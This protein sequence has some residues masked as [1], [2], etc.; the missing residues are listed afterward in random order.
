[1][2]EK[3]TQGGGSRC[4]RKRGAGSW[5]QGSVAIVLAILLADAVSGMPYVEEWAIWLG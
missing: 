5:L 3:K 1:M 2:Q 4:G